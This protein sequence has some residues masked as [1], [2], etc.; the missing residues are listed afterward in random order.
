MEEWLEADPRLFGLDCLIIGRQV[1]TPHGGAIDLLG[2]DPEGNVVILEL[3]RDRTPRDTVAQIL[4]YASWVHTLTAR[5][6]H[7]Q[8]LQYFLPRM[9]DL[10]TAFRTRFGISLPDT[11]N[12]KQRLLIVASE[13]DDSSKRI[14]QYL[15]KVFGLDINTA[16]FTFFREGET[17]L[18]TADWLMDEDEVRERSEARTQAP[19][20]G[21]WYVN[22][23]DDSSRSWDDARAY[24]FLAAGGG[25]WYSAALKK[26]EVGSRLFA[27]QKGYGYV[28]YGIVTSPAVMVKDFRTASGQPLL[29][30]P[31][32]Q[33]NLGHDKDDPDLAEYAIGVDWKKAVGLSEAK[34]FN[35]AFANQNIVC[36][37]RHEP[38]LEF[39]KQ[40]FG[41][42]E[43]G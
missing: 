13:F 18:L 23:G 11:L 5:D 4:D 3:K 7:A 34:T 37:L 14:V 29:S 8:S 10:P 36:K 31:L 40:Q 27:Y 28:G 1:H 9:T 35:G 26:L 2:L 42:A 43:Q 24:G 20:S 17:E 19:W 25:S 32:R 6:V 33:P 15:A 41:V 16:F 21:Y 30:L 12:S 39:L 22:A 38:T